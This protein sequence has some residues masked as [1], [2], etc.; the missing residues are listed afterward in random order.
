MDP[1][2]PVIQ[3][4]VAGATASAQATA[5]SAVRDAYAGLKTVIE[6][7]FA[8]H[9]STERALAQHEK[10]PQTWEAPLKAELAEVDADQD[11][12]IIEAA[13]HLPGVV[14]PAQAAAGKYN[15]QIRG[16]AQGLAQA[17]HQHVSM[18][19]GDVPQQS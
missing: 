10:A 15:V 14:H 19:F 7:R 11:P 17:D 6:R 3:A 16:S 18:T 13:R 2:T 5:G 9:P 8:G 12:E 4:L 1:I